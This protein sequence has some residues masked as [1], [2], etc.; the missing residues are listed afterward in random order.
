MGLRGVEEGSVVKKGLRGV[1]IRSERVHF[2]KIDKILQLWTHLD[3]AVMIIVVSRSKY[4]SHKN[5][6]TKRDWT[7]FLCTD[8]TTFDCLRFA[9]ESSLGWPDKHRNRCNGGALLDA[10]SR[11][12]DDPVASAD[13]RA[14]Y[15]ADPFAAGHRRGS[16]RGR[17]VTGT[18]H[19]AL[20]ILAVVPVG[21]DGHRIGAADDGARSDTGRGGS[22]GRS[23]GVAPKGGV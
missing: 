13:H 22:A 4:V 12:S 8:H 10:V 1:D 14:R 23:S 15:L 11:N 20:P 16:W 6:R 18:T 19:D 3:E 17:A 2:L 9:A 7:N 21:N 5:Y